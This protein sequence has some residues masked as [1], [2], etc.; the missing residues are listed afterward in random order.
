MGLKFGP[1]EVEIQIQNGRLQIAPFSSTVNNGQFNF[2]GEAN[3][4]QKPTLLK[5]PG[6]IQIMKYI[7]VN[8]ATTDKLLMYLNP[9]FAD[10][11]NVSGV[12]NFSCERLAIPLA[13]ATKNDIEVIGTISANQ[14]RLQASDLLGQILS[15]A[16]TSAR[17]E[18]I[19]I[20][21]TRFV[22]QDG[23]LRYDDMQMIVGNNPINFQDAVIGLDK[24]LNMRVTLPYTTRGRTA[25]VGEERAGERISLLLGG[26]IDEPELDLGKLLEEQLKEQL[27]EKLQEALEELFK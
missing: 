13:G 25:R 3:F 5:T 15:V 21:P 22:L 14:L 10:A 16:G 19:T 24:S 12:V 6:P 20:S 1:T 27:E 9:I 4:K 26:T 8:K 17:G 2:A 23:F 7:Q 11:V 18:D